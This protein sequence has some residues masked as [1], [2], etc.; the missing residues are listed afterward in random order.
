MKPSKL[1]KIVQSLSKEE[2]VDWKRFLSSP[3]FN[4]DQNLLVGYNV[5]AKYFPDLDSKRLTKEKVYEKVFPGIT[6]NDAKWRNLS[7]KMVKSLEMFLSVLEMRNDE[8]EQR[9]FF[10]KSLGKR[11]LYSIF[12]KE[13]KSLDYSLSKIYPQD[14][15]VLLERALLNQ[16]FYYHKST[17]KI[18]QFNYLHDAKIQL[19]NYYSSQHMIWLCEKLL[20][21]TIQKQSTKNEFSKKKKFNDNENQ[22]IFLSLYKSIHQLLKTGR[23]EDYQKAKYLFLDNIDH[24]S[25][26]D[27]QF[28]LL[29]LI[30]FSVRKN[31]KGYHSYRIEMF[32]LYKSGLEHKILTENRQLTDTTFRNIVANSAALNRFG[33]AEKFI[34]EYEKYLPLNDKE[35]ATVMAKANLYFHQKE[36]SKVIDLL[37]SFTPNDITN[38]LIAKTMLLRSYFEYFLDN[39][40]Y[41]DLLLS[42][43]SAFEKLVK[44]KKKLPQDRI[45]GC[46][47]LSSTI[48]RLSKIIIENKWNNKQK[49]ILLGEIK[50]QNMLIGKSWLIEKNKII[51]KWVFNPLHN[52]KKLNL[53]PN[54]IFNDNKS[55]YSFPTNCPKLKLIIP[56]LQAR[57]RII[58]SRSRK[59]PA[60]KAISQTHKPH[61]ITAACARTIVPVK[62]NRTRRMCGGCYIGRGVASS[63]R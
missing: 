2:F 10:I 9:K 11:N 58:R 54:I 18:E 13:V 43:S 28:G 56:S 5:L 23:D 38:L 55:T 25:M 46:L 22:P 15:T 29:H 33:W 24:L 57:K 26:N 6:W 20:M 37:I 41:Y 51:M 61:F 16:S 30:N 7:S 14:L 21:E 48:R 52:I 50:N 4:N 19:E 12:K 39:P 53:I 27:K 45:I 34:E 62:R 44:R 40:S 32:D 31:N 59:P 49:E 35:K 36:F 47:N 42:Y 60:R 63:F 3:F 17:N 8:N 1:T